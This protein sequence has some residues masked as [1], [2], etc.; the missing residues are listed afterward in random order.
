MLF[1]TPMVKSLLADLKTQTRRMTGLGEVNEN[2]DAWEFGGFS[3]DF[4]GPYF[5]LKGSFDPEGSVSRAGHPYGRSGDLIYVR[6]SWNVI[7]LI[8]SDFTERQYY[9][10][11][12]ANGDTKGSVMIR[13]KPS[14]HMPKDAARI[15]LRNCD[16][17]FQRI[18][19][20][21]KE[22]CIAEGI[23]QVTPGFY[24]NYMSN[25]G[26]TFYSEADSFRSLWNSI[27]GV[28]SPVQTRVDGKLVTVGY[29]CYPFDRE[30]GKKYEGKTTWRGKPLT[31]VC[32]P[33]VRVVDFK[34]VC[35][36]GVLPAEAL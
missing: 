15:W 5:I 24:R 12:D 16:E 18:A 33:W 4:G 22:D 25:D 35:K 1:S 31:V 17:R 7:S 11:A 26:S 10:K 8:Y 30:S 2:P 14:I 36:D 9:F 21:S 32:N 34:V 20:I 13:W 28:P 19:E 29:V 6:E 3:E 27:N 23:E